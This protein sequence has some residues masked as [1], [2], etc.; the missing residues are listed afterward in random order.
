L[1]DGRFDTV[2]GTPRVRSRI[3]SRCLPPIHRVEVGAR[4]FLTGVEDCRYAPSARLAM[5]GRGM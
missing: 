4:P 1:P 3:P 2:S 5:A